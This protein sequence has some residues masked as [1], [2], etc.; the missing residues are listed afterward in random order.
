MRFARAFGSPGRFYNPAIALWTGVGL[1]IGASFL[2]YGD[3]PWLVPFDEGQGL[4]IPVWLDVAMDLFVGVSKPAFRVVSWLLEMPVYG[5]RDFY[6]WLPWSV[7]LFVVVVLAHVA[8]GWRVA[9]FCLLALCYILVTGFWNKAA[10]TLALVTVSLPLS[11]SVGLALGIL[12]HGSHRARRVIEPLLDFMQTIPT[13]AYLVPGLI[14]FGFGP[15]V[16]LIA[17]AVFAMPPMARNVMLGLSRVPADVVDAAIMAGGTNRQIL[18]WVKLPTSLPTV[19]MGVNQTIL[20][21]FAMVVIAAVLGSGDDLGWAVLYTMRRAEFGQSLMAGLAIV[22][23]AMMMDRVTQGLARRRDRMLA[24]DLES[25]VRQRYAAWT[26]TIVTVLLLIAA[27]AF[28]PFLWHFPGAWTLHP[29]EFLN[30]IISWINI[31]Y[32]HVTDNIKNWTLFYYMLPMKL[33]LDDIVRPFSWGF[34]LTNPIRVGYAALVLVLAAAA[35]MAA[36]WRIGLTLAAFGI[37]FYVGLTEL[38][39]PAFLVPVTVLAWRVG[40]RRMGIFALF[41]LS[42]MLTSGFWLRSMISIYLCGSAV[43]IC[44]V[45][46]VSLGVWAALNDRISAI[47]R[48]VNDTLQSIPLFVFLIP[49]VVLFK[50]GEFAG[51]LAIIMYAIVPTIRY[52]ELGIRLV[53][54][55]VVEAAL[56]MGCSRRQLLFGVQL[57]LALPE[58][59][60][61]INQTVLFGL[62]MLV[63]TALVGTKGLGQ[64]IYKSLAGGGFGMG[65]TA[66]LCMA[67]I[68]MTTDGVIQSWSARRKRELGLFGV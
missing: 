55:E 16:G 57:P 48:P 26:F 1:V 43:L 29:Y 40:G 32:P 66:A 11:I 15:T 7:V 10:L 41:S 22:L 65:I 9:L 27:S 31:N 12:G 63:I 20:A 44:V 45:I 38:P 25:R 4:P 18:W 19:M 6:S 61:G 51:L 46:G 37:V 35:T 59:M 60:L 53:D 21:T 68:A 3:V 42:F 8:A 58:I 13:F 28:V 47:I 34:T 14:L 33:G 17:A 62:G 23:V 49:V 67:F 52:T 64:V 56:S 39:W 5:F 30:R 50:V 36:N 54:A 2:L 24:V